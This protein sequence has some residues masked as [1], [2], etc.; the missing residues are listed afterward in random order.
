MKKTMLMTMALM[1]GLSTMAWS[2]TINYADDFSSWNWDTFIPTV[3]GVNANSRYWYDESGNEIFGGVTWGT[4]M[5]YK[6]LYVN[7]SGA[8][9]GN[10]YKN[11]R[12]DGTLA[13]TEFF[14]QAAV[15]GQFQMDNGV[16]WD[17]GLFYRV[18][19]LDPSGNGYVG[20]VTRAGSMTLY[21][22]TGGT[23]AEIG[24]GSGNGGNN[25]TVGLSVTGGVVTLNYYNTPGTTYSVSANDATYQ[26]FTTIGY[27]GFYGYSE[28]M[29][30]DNVSLNATIVP[31]PATMV[32]LGLG[33][34]LG[35][36]RRK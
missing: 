21:R 6:K 17:N 7:N 31:E 1:A 4:P 2:A 5:D 15:S 23:L 11:F 28:R 32:L 3:G 36:Y 20:T 8:F 13:S 10:A 24:T 18:S 9:N 25:R 35:W 26:Y 27:G 33:G 22:A 14:T 16:D 30:I 19:V 34:V 29:G 12:L